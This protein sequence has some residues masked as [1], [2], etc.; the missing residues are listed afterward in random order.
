[1]TAISIPH[2]EDVSVEN[3]KYFDFFQER[4]GQMPN[5]YAMMSYAQQAL[6]SYVRLQH[7]KQELNR[8]EREAIGLVMAAVNGSA[9][10][11][12]SHYRTAKLND[13]TDEQVSEISGGTASFDGRLDV[14]VRLTYAIASTRGKPA[15]PLLEQFFQNGY[16]PAHLVDLVLCIGDNTI[17][18]FLCQ[19]MMIPSDDENFSL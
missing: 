4:I 10:C 1:M 19:V 6:D 3:R 15:L 11:M 18:N 16:T 12:E 9:Y 7:R 17:A 8:R 2:R 5:L 13:L 14:L